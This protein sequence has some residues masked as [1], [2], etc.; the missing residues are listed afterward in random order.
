MR[1]MVESTWKEP[2]LIFQRLK[3]KKALFARRYHGQN[4][5][6]KSCVVYH[7]ELTKIEKI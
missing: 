5:Q 4:M 6:A 7:R 1:T 2:Y 3:E